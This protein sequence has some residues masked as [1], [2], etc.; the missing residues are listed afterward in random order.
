MDGVKIYF[1]NA[2][3]V[4]Y[5][6]PIFCLENQEGLRL[7]LFLAKILCPSRLFLETKSL[8]MFLQAQVHIF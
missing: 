2:P 6:F 7:S 3:T 1:N 8:Q 4:G 5:F